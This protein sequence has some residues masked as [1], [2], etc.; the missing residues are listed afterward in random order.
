MEQFSIGDKVLHKS[1]LDFKMVVKGFGVVWPND[2]RKT[3]DG[4]PNPEYPICSYYNIHTN[5]WEEKRFH[6]SELDP[7]S[8][9][10]E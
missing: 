4:I 1:T 5:K 7:Y 8:D 6:A 3:I 10:T 2:Q 9:G